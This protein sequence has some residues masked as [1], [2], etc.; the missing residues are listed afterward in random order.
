MSKK[1]RILK[2]P[3]AWMFPLL[4]FPIFLS[5]ISNA[6]EIPDYLGK[7]SSLF[8]FQPFKRKE[9]SY[10]KDKTITREQKPPASITPKSSFLK[11]QEDLFD[12]GS[13]EKRFAYR[14]EKWIVWV[15]WLNPDGK[16]S[17]SLPIWIDKNK[18]GH[19]FL[20]ASVNIGEEIRP[21]FG[22]NQ[23]LSLCQTLSLFHS[24]NGEVKPIASPIWIIIQS[25]DNKKEEIWTGEGGWE[26]SSNLFDFRNVYSPFKSFLRN[27]SNPIYKKLSQYE[28]PDIVLFLQ[29]SDDKTNKQMMENPDQ[30]L[31]N[32]K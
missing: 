29:K 27:Q 17:E 11:L 4:S 15:C 13:F 21:N 7:G 5:F 18:D 23:T 2:G 16:I 26:A 31:L 8:L 28:W 30:I 3:L 9:S 14:T 19:Y 12:Q 6:K 22:E 20:K 32:F 25:K 1:S 24:D 10:S